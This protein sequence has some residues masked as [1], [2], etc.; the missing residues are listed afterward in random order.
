MI[1]DIL[2][3]NH[4]GLPLV[5]Q[6]FGDCHSFSTDIGILSSYVSAIQILSKDLAGNEI[7]L[8]VMND[9]KMAFYMKNGLTFNIICDLEDDDK[10]IQT[11]VKKIADIFLNTYE[12]VI[13]P[14]N[15]DV[16]QFIGFGQILIELNIAQKNCGG[17]PECVVCPNSKNT[18]PLKDFIQSFQKMFQL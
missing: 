11:K 15:G 18:L 4:A 1:R 14:F 8:I 16:S 5:T 3:I 6:N 10:V 17:R 7:N 9:K 12:H 13:S 2:I